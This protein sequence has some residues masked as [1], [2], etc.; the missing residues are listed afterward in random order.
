M[1]AQLEV[2]QRKL[3]LSKQLLEIYPLIEADTHERFLLTLLERLSE[4]RET[5]TKLR[6]LKK[7][8]V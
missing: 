1:R 5:R 2:L 8:G 3:R 7:C 6:N 4:E